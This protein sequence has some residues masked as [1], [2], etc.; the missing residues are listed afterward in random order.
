MAA[1][2]ISTHRPL[3]TESGFDNLEVMNRRLYTPIN[4]V[5]EDMTFYWR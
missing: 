1:Q 5:E 3:A 2:T 4:P